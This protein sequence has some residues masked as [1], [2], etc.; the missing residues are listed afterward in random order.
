L[1]EDIA[2]DILGA[3]ADTAMKR[4]ESGERCAWREVDDLSRAVTLAQSARQDVGAYLAD[5]PG[6]VDVAT[7]SQQSGGLHIFVEEVASGSRITVLLS[8]LTYVLSV[9]GK[10]DD[11]PAMVAD[12]LGL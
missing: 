8:V 12:M 11:V 7:D 3:G 5:H 6:A 9:P 1:S 4:T 10:P 2:R